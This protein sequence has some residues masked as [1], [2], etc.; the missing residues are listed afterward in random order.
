[1]A[2]FTLVAVKGTEVDIKVEA[3][4]TPAEV[5]QVLV[6]SRDSL[7][8]LIGLLHE[9]KG[10]VKEFY[11][12]FKP[13]LQRRAAAALDRDGSSWVREEEEKALRHEIEMEKLRIELAEL[14]AK[15]TEK[16]N[17]AVIE[18]IRT[19]ALAEGR[20]AER[21]E[22]YS[23]NIVTGSDACVKTDVANN[24]VARIST[25]NGNMG[26]V[27]NEVVSH[28]NHTEDTS[29][30]MVVA[31]IPTAGNEALNGVHVGSSEIHS[32]RIAETTATVR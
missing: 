19:E 28:R 14:K 18:R 16:D 21:A 8:D 22:R 13:I 9:A 12:E 23:R 1:M 11:D 7:K 2:K 32:R 4:M 3:E 20:A 6:T 10:T 5:A 31:R 30:E 17:E 26:T 25:T 24:G 15:S 29:T 27:L